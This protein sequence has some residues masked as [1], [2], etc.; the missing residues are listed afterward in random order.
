MVYRI[1]RHLSLLLMVA[2]TISYFTIPNQVIAQSNTGEEIG[3]AIIEEL[4]ESSEI[5][6]GT[7]RP[8]Q[9][10]SPCG[11]PYNKNNDATKNVFGFRDQNNQPII[12]TGLPEYK[13][14]CWLMETNRT[15]VHKFNYFHTPQVKAQ[16][17]IYE[18][19]YKLVE[20][21]PVYGGCNPF[22][23]NADKTCGSNNPRAFNY[24]TFHTP[25]KATG[26]RGE[27][28]ETYQQHKLQL[29][30]F[31]DGIADSPAGAQPNAFII[32]H[33][34]TK[35]V[36]GF[37][38]FNRSRSDRFLQNQLSTD[39]LQTER[40]SKLFGLASD[41]TN[42]DLDFIEPRNA[43]TYRGNIA[44]Q[45]S[46]IRHYIGLVNGLSGATLPYPYTDLGTSGSTGISGDS[47]SIKRAMEV[48]FAGVDAEDPS[49]GV[50]LEDDIANASS[51]TSFDAPPIIKITEGLSPSGTA[52]FRLATG[53]AVKPTLF[54]QNN[55]Y[56][57]F[58]MAGSPS[59]DETIVQALGGK[60][61]IQNIYLVID[62]MGNIGFVLNKTENGDFFAV[63]ADR[64][65]GWLVR[66]AFDGSDGNA[67]RNAAIRGPGRINLVLYRAVITK[68]VY[69]EPYTYAEKPLGLTG[70]FGFSTTTVACAPS[71]EG[72]KRS[73]GTT[74]SLADIQPYI[75]DYGEQNVGFDDTA[76]YPE[77]LPTKAFRMCLNQGENGWL[78][79]W[80]VKFDALNDQQKD[81]C[82]TA[83]GKGFFNELMGKAICGVFSWIINM[84]ITFAGFSV[85]FMVEAIGLQ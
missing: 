12:L 77:Q 71:F 33:P 41:E 47:A 80:G 73:N 36:Y 10:T 38:G 32:V 54:G 64:L 7:S 58:Q 27:V 4:D 76:L 11:S 2:I 30:Y 82:T 28:V 70:L 78:T 72:K 61:A 21:V 60:E 14:Q 62:M 42:D 15:L 69:H 75:I 9:S 26:S 45:H 25:G 5:T 16:N 40:A 20:N 68:R 85:D 65:D 43:N 39:Q 79:K 29:Y 18:Q 46:T 17:I 34:T 67:S 55:N 44:F 81:A 56:F 31:I 63:N 35:Y 37:Y 50:S 6:E 52:V 74:V 57:F 51:P 49:K 8:G 48:V 1:H 13:N 22:R 53:R 24:F 19:R 23:S 83:F 66:G 3:D 84:A 59:T